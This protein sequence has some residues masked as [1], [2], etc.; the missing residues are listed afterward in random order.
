MANIKSINEILASF[1]A[2]LRAYNKSIDTG[3]N[4][5]I[6]DLLITPMAVA[7]RLLSV[8]AVEASDRH[9]LSKSTG[10]ILD[11]EGTNYTLRRGTGTYA[12]VSVTFWSEIA[13]TVPVYI[14]KGTQASTPGT[15]FDSPVS[16]IT[17]SDVSLSAAS[18]QAYYSHDRARY[19]YTTSALCAEA[20]SRGN[21]GSSTISVISGSIA[22]IAGVTNLNAAT[23]G[24]GSEDDDD[25]RERIR[26]KRAGRGLNVPEGLRGFVRDA[27]F[28]D[29]YA[30]RTEDA[31]S[32]RCDG[33]DIF[34]VDPYTSAA[35]D[36]FTYYAS[37]NKYYLTNRPVKDV[38]SVVSVSVGEL[39]LTD[40][41][42]FIDNSSPI[43]RSK[44]A[45][46]YIEVRLSASIPNGTQFTVTY[47]YNEYIYN[48][49]ASLEND[50]NNVLTSNVMAKRAF[51]VNL[52]INASLTLLTNADIAT[53]KTL[54]RNALSQFLSTYRL[55]DDI[56]KSDLIIVLQEGYGD[57]VVD[58][59][60]AVVIN[61]FYLTDEF[62]TTYMPV[63]ETITVSPTQYVIYGQAVLV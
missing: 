24:T 58:S 47:A 49:Q 46:D 18:A 32:E 33:I 17:I 30:I 60:D 35:T 16:F 52:Y 22:G 14:P 7:G 54:C 34:V 10:S 2:F 27:G 48:L 50:K 6:R 29:A 26:L 28:Q 8:Q 3:D 15:P 4:S 61:S 20:G 53:T 36:T 19:E 57:Y 25:I 11:D 38:T 51:P 45:Q 44:Y 31:D 59:V 23:G 21:V 12:T 9:V 37:T 41:D 5:L 1:S 55:G 62:G 39:G 13:P 63:Q 40:Y 43:R 56:Q 42:V